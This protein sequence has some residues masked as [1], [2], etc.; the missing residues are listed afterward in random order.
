[1]D[2]FSVIGNASR[3]RERERESELVFIFLALANIPCVYHNEKE[4]N[5][6][7]GL[8]QIGTGIIITIIIDINVFRRII[9][10]HS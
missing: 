6:E 1:M 9:K 5:R 10:R 2:L 8:C 7:E 4:T 3:E